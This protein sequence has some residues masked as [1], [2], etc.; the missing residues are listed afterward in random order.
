MAGEF[1]PGGNWRSEGFPRVLD[2]IDLLTSDQEAPLI[3]AVS[4]ALKKAYPELE[5]IP[6][7]IPGMEAATSNSSGSGPSPLPEAVSA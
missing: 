4:Q 3:I 2:F 5:T 1:D 6:L 7:P